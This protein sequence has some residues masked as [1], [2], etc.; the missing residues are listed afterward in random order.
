MRISTTMMSRL[1]VA[2]VAQNRAQLARTQ[3]QAVTGRRLNR[4]SD[5]PIDYHTARDFKTSV[6]ETN[7]FLR[8]IDASRSR[9]GATESALNDIV[10]LLSEA[11]VMAIAAG[12]DSNAS[13]ARPARLASVESLFDRLFDEGNAQS[14]DGG[15]VF[16]GLTSDTPAFSRTGSF[17][18]GSPPPTVTFDGD[19]NQVAVE[20]DQN[21]YIDITLDGS[22]VFQG[23]I[24]LFQAIG[25]LWSGIDAQDSTLI[26]QAIGELD[27]AENQVFAELARIGESDATANRYQDRLRLRQETLAERLSLVEDADVY[28]VYSDLANQETA[29]QASLQ[30]TSSMLGPTLLDFI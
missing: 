6:S 7:R 21:V 29:L 17:V 2:Q 13:V 27:A 19:G 10:E 11:R 5:D 26:Q 4:P 25:T 8:A 28:Q 14:V 15:Y 16:S 9:T 12:S 24:D 3:E 20:V 18:S 22:R 1:G 23:G 30:V